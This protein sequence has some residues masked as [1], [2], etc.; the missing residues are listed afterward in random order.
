MNYSLKVTKHL[1]TGTNPV[2]EGQ[3]R[4]TTSKAEKR[5]KKRK[6]LQLTNN[7]HPDQAET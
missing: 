7:S 2:T 1:I 3:K 5:E 4:R 6:L